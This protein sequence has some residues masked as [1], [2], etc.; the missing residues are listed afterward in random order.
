MSNVMWLE[1]YRPKTLDEVIGQD[2]Y[3]K[4]LKSL[5]KKIRNNDIT[6]VPHMIFIGPPSVGKTTIVHAFLRDCF[7]D[8][9]KNNL[10]EKNSSDERGID[11][12]KTDIKNA[13]KQ[14]PIGTYIDDNGVERR[15]PFNVIFLDE[16][17]GMTGDAQAALRRT[18]EKYPNTVFILAANYPNKIIEPIKE[19][20][21]FSNMRFNR[22][23]EDDIKKVLAPIIR[24]KGIDISD[25]A[26]DK[27]AKMSNGSARRAITTLWTAHLIDGKITGDR[28]NITDIN[29][30]E[31]DF[32]M[33]FFNALDDK[34]IKGVNE[35][36]TTLYYDLGL[37]GEQILYLIFENIDYLNNE[38][39]AKRI[40]KNVAQGMY[41]CANAIDDYI[42]AKAVIASMVME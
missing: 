41:W 17:D 7:G 38:T 33:Q 3:V 6:S 18:M 36:V 21:A 27:I 20:C 13:A 23:T 28:I 19:R 42:M 12:V 2:E 15:I 1:E 34:N 10:I 31:R 24:D 4:A 32:V 39:I 14:S 40:L 9:Y 37:S 25:D 35:Y 29:G 30:V 26:I 16:V 8:A 5:A 11:V 22:L